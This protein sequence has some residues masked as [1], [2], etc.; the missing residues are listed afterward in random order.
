[1]ANK[2]IHKHSSVITDGKAKLPTASQLEY[3]ELAINYAD[4][5]E[6]ISMKNSANQI[7]EFKSTNNL[8]NIIIENELITAS[9]LNDLNKRIKNV[10]ENVGDYLTDYSKV[11][12]THGTITLSGDVTGSGTIGSGTTEIN[13]TATVADNSHA[14]TSDNITDSISDL[15]GLTTSA[16]GLVQGKAV[17]ALIEEMENSEYVIAWAVTEL[18]TRMDQLEKTIAKLQ[19]SLANVTILSV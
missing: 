11:D 17:A 12:H 5:V 4:G 16:T 8:E 2:I 9:A 19:E 13:I 10:E 6:T 14:H 15:S 18:E 1:M 7:V 3:G